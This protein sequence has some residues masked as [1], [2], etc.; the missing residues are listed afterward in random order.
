MSARARRVVV[1][2]GGITGLSA[3]WRL[4]QSASGPVHITVLETT[5]RWG[6]KLITERLVAEGLALDVDAGADSFVTRKPELWDLAHELGIDDALL[7]LASQARGTRLLHGGELVPVPLSPPA[8]AGTPLMSPLGKLRLLAEPLVPARRD[9]TDESLAEF[10]RRRLGR[11]AADHLVCP[12]LAGIYNADPETQSIMTTS[13]IMRELEREHGSIFVASFVRMLRAR[14]RATRR[15][16]FVGIRGGARTLVD[17]LVRSVR[18]EMHL[19]AAA[20]SILA[21]GSEY[22]VEME[23]GATIPAEA[24]LLATPANVAARLLGDLAPAAAGVLSS[25]SHSSIGTLVVAVRA[26]SSRPDPR[27]SGVMIPRREGRLIDAIRWAT[28]GEAAGKLE[29][30]KLFFGGAAPALMEMDDAALIHAVVAE[31]SSIL[32]RSISP[33]ASAINRWPSSYPEA[34]V[35]HLAVV[36]EIERR[37][38][39]GILAAGASYRGLGVP[40]CIR[41]ASRAASDVWSYLNGIDEKETH[42]ASHA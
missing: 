2:G 3:A 9:E 16:R 35:G 24:V 39:P 32:G 7:P 41:Q 25:V 36:D 14:R 40:D 13:P 37:L 21:H 34:R 10:A 19:G 28:P 26:G 33:V 23:S 11:E 22:A 29:V 30:V 20:R 27:M 17:A 1:V 18:A 6:G 31:A 42:S 15:P 4:Q 8:L 5:D 38:P 12:I